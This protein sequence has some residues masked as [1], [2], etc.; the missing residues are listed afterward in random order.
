MP[1]LSDL[2]REP[3]PA[4][5]QGGLPA[6]ACASDAGE[7]EKVRRWYEAAQREMSRIRNDVRA[8]ITPQVSV[9]EML[10]RNLVNDLGPGDLAL[11]RAFRGQSSDYPVDNAVNV[12][13][14]AVTVGRGLRYGAEALT[15]LALA[16]L[17]HEVGMWTIPDAIILK[18]GPLS[19][20]EQGAVRSHP[21]RGR[22][23]LA[24]LGSPYDRIAAIVAQ[25][26]E[27]WDGSGYPCRL[28]GSDI[29]EPAQ[30]IGLADLVDALVTPRPY[31]KRVS[32]HHALRE[33]LVHA[34]QQFAYDVL[35]ALG[36]EITLYPVGSCVRLNTG[37]RAKVG[38]VN[39]RYPLRPFV[40]I[41][42]RSSGESGVD[43]K[44]T[45]AVH[46]VEVLQ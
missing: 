35:K 36:D 27:R 14:V 31:K 13:I 15:E 2:V 26:H 44:Q 24:A 20:D 10:A 7:S 45:P 21:E 3:G 11:E 22:R 4:A 19:H 30:I 9:C 41:E 32:P 1:R 16:G 42:G 12:A 43:L 39:P 29:T 46:I 6:A 5:A 40:R 25:E 28:K 23:I 34:K 17:L 18:P 37:E 8:G 38:R 33:V